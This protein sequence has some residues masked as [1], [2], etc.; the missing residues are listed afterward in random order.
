MQRRI[1]QKEFKCG[2]DFA[3]LYTVVVKNMKKVLCSHCETSF[4]ID[5]ISRRICC[6]VCNTSLELKRGIFENHFIGVKKRKPSR[7]WE[8]PNSVMLTY[9]L[10]KKS[11]KKKKPIISMNT[12]V[13]IVF[14]IFG[15]TLIGYNIFWIV[16]DPITSVANA[17]DKIIDDIT[18]YIKFNLP[19]KE[20]T[21]IK[22]HSL[23]MNYSFQEEL[24]KNRNVFG[25]VDED[26]RLPFDV[27][28]SSTFGYRVHPTSGKKKFHRGIDLPRTYNSKI[29]PALSGTVIFSGQKNGYGNLIVVNHNN[30]YTT[31]Y[32]HNSVNLVKKGDYV[33]QSAVIGLVGDTG[34]TTGPHLHFELRKNDVPLNPIKFLHLLNTDK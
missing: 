5:T 11:L 23:F 21:N 13:G 3:I 1:I 33:D 9:S 19:E 4:P 32:G 2:I 30:G 22:S 24:K 25:S 31:F 14:F 17:D 8:L 29:R 27:K 6:P 7:D 10:I 16:K 12:L 20:L 15:L 26:F 28:P 34:L 18:A